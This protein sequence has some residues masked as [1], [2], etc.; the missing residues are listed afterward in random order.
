LP[1]GRVVNF[2]AV[3]DQ[4]PVEFQVVLAAR[5]VSEPIPLMN[6]FDQGLEP[7]VSPRKQLM[8]RVDELKAQHL[9]YQKKP[10]PR[11]RETDE[12]LRELEIEIRQIYDTLLALGPDPTP[13]PA[14]PT[15]QVTQQDYAVEFGGEQD[16]TFE[17]GFTARNLKSQQL[18]QNFGARGGVWVSNIV[19][20][21]AAERAGLKTGDVIV[22]AQERVVLSAAQLQ[23]FLSTQRGPIVLKIVRNKASSIVS[24]N[25]Q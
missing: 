19:K 16:L 6:P 2:A 10:R 9:A 22:G 15:T 5:P 1:A 21:S 3:R 11:S 12:A 18:A 7:A 8:S 4:K 23:A 24:L 17:L 20:N 13:L 25:L 14:S